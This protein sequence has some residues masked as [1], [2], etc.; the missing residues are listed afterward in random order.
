MTAAEEGE[1]WKGR[2]GDSGAAVLGVLLSGEHRSQLLTQELLPPSG[3]LILGVF[4][5]AAG[6]ELQV[7]VNQAMKRK[8][9]T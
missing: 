7:L 3:N 4:S 5:H 6:Q 8:Q 2:G 9:V 1:P